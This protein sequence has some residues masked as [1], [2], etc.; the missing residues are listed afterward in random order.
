MSIFTNFGSRGR[1]TN[2][3]RVLLDPKVGQYHSQA[4]LS[5]NQQSKLVSSLS[6]SQQSIA[7]QLGPPLVISEVIPEPEFEST[8]IAS[9]NSGV[10]ESEIAAV[11][12][13]TG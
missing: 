5:W 7:S 3:A 10:D 8:I 2:I 4:T 12:G 1:E 11:D 13:H 9:D 6:R